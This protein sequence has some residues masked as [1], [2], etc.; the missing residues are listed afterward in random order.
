MAREPW[1]YLLLLTVRN[2]E[3]PIW[4]RVAVD[5]SISLGKLHNI[6][7]LLM[8]WYDYHL[9]QFTIGETVF[10]PSPEDYEGYGP[11]PKSTRKRLSTCFSKVGDSIQYEYDFGDGWGIDITLEDEGPK[12]FG[13][14]HIGYAI[15]ERAGPLE[16]SG[17]PFGYME[18]LQII[19]DPRHEEHSEILEWIPEGFDAEFFD[20]K[21]I[22][23]ELDLL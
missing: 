17:G 21:Q 22:N 14:R 16:D 23:E 9:H 20:E 8:G 10:D 11:T 7:Q 4:R 3:P 1:E 19:T 2:I 6:I 15:G 12:T 13:D 5:A 18:K